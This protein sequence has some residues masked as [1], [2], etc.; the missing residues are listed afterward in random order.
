MQKIYSMFRCD[1]AACT[2]DGREIVASLLKELGLK[3][4]QVEKL[5]TV[6][7]AE[8]VRAYMKVSP[9]IAMKGGYIGGAPLVND[10][11]KGNPLDFGLREHAYDI[12]LMIGSVFGEF[13]FA[14]AA[15]NKKELTEE[16]KEGIIGKVYK[17]RTQEMIG[18]FAKAYPN[19]NPVDLLN[20]DRA[21]RQPSKEL[22]KLHAQ[23]GN[24]GAYL[25]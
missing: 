11:Y 1:P 4:D 10:Y 5:E 15:Y 19:K 8:L 25:Y 12:P 7:Y 9:A 14:P 13:S 24:A 23:K 6:P 18:A 16:E 17:D 21:M 2:G 20:I 3:E 22:A